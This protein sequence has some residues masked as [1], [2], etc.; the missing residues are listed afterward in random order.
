V[1]QTTTVVIVS[2]FRKQAGPPLTPPT[3]TL[4]LGNPNPN[5][6]PSPN[7]NPN[8]NPNPTLTLT[9]T[10]TITRT[11]RR[12]QAIAAGEGGTPGSQLSLRLWQPE[13]LVMHTL[14]KRRCNHRCNTMRRQ[15]PGTC[16]CN[17]NPNPTLIARPLPRVLVSLARAQV[18]TGI[19]IL[20][21]Y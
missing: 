17:S 10:L 20:V 6:N 2:K 14:S 13:C 18:W 16:D 4:T 9:L 8:P 3:L 12:A 5:P 7:P 11:H 21:Y 15:F 1:Q 19:G